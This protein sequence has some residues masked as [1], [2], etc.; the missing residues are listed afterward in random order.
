MQDCVSGGSVRKGQYIGKSGHSGNASGPHVH[1][2]YKYNGQQYDPTYALGGRAV[3]RNG[4]TLQ[5]GGQVPSGILINSDI[6]RTPYSERVN[7]VTQPQNDGGPV[8][9]QT[10][11]S[12]INNR[13]LTSQI[14]PEQ[15][16]LDKWVKDN[17][18]D[19][20]ETSPYNMPVDDHAYSEDQYVQHQTSDDEENNNNESDNGV[21]NGN[22]DGNGNGSGNGK[23]GGSGKMGYRDWET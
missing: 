2:E 10:P 21:G 1:L 13:V 15:T 19:L 5:S 11:E 12:E 14:F 18:V 20:G 22:G 9:I 6:E 7:Y 4:Q 8:T 17:Q 16:N 3:G 23:G